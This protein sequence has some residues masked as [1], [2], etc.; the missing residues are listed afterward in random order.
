MARIDLRSPVVRARIMRLCIPVPLMVGL[1]LMGAAAMMR[2][3]IT[4]GGTAMLIVSLAGTAII[5]MMGWDEW[6]GM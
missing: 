6:S 1:D 3:G 5:A 2:D 4:G